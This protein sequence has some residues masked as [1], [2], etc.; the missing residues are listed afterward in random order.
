MTENN[1][2]NL[3]LKLL[4]G[5]PIEI[6]NVGKIHP[7]TIDDILDITLEKYNQHL[8]V[9]C[10]EPEDI[11]KFLNITDEVQ[12]YEFLYINCLQSKE[13]R[14]IV[15][16]A[17]TFFF[18]EEVRFSELYGFYLG[19]IEEKRVINNENFE[20]VKYV[21]K[22][23]NCIAS[24]ED[25]E[26]K[27]NPANERARKILEKLK[28]DKATRER[29]K[30]KENEENMLSL[31]DLISILAAYGNNLNIFNIWDLTFFQF[32]NQFNR[33]K[34]LKDYEVNIQILMNTTE[35]D[36]VKYQHWLSKIVKE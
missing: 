2:L 25:E 32:N 28:K 3:E 35:P 5:C 24:K 19:E 21:I 22:K 11:K 7:V 31:F 13:Y 9:L 34:I 15:F 23:L 4:R 8:N 10:I 26:E 14:D 18:R 29:I 30:Q 16:E 6:Q 12:T 36:K 1:N 17:L 20:E 27:Y 33:M